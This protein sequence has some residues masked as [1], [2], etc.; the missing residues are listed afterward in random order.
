MTLEECQTMLATAPVRTFGRWGKKNAKAKNGKGTGKTAAAAAVEAGETRVGAEAGGAGAA[1]KR[2]AP[3]AGP[4]LAPGTPQRL[5]AKASK[6]AANK[7]AP[8]QPA[9][10]SKTADKPKKSA[11]KKKT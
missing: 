4:G 10:A 7:K 3:S 9:A 6:A 8:L 1:I 2:K 11:A 5:A